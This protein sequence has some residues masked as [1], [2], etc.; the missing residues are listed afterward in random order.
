M[1]AK[2]HDQQKH[3]RRH[4]NSFDLYLLEPEGRPVDSQAF[5]AAL[6]KELCI[7]PD[8]ADPSRY[9]FVDP[10]TG[11]FFAFVL[12]PNLAALWRKLLAPPVE[13]AEGL[14]GEPDEGE[15]GGMGR[16]GSGEEGPDAADER[17]EDDEVDG[18]EEEEEASHAIEMLPL[19]L[20]VPLFCPRFFLREAL[21]FAQRLAAR[22][23]LLVEHPS[24]EGSHGPAVE[25][26]EGDLSQPLKFEDLLGP[27][28]D[29][30][31]QA[32]MAG[33]AEP[34]IWTLQKAEAWWDYSSHRA[35]LEE[36]LAI[37]APRLQAA[38]HDG[39]LKSLC[40]WEVGTPTVF[41]R[42]ELILVRQE[43]RRK[44]LFW[45]RRIVEE[46]ITAGDTI[47]DLL[48]PFG[49]LRSEPTEILIFREAERMPSQVKA[50]LE[51]LRLEPIETARRT[52]L[53][54]VLDFELEE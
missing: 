38:R 41:P 16:E 24:P 46:G 35:R 42:A 40:V 10:E 19:A 5:V 52:P 29:M 53:I 44:G 21:G 20:S 37:H 4:L 6:A 27:W 26:R 15:E 33:M 22:G 48:A 28:I 9:H 39:K 25:K 34:T 12:H 3:R 54:G 36:E 11:V 31:R 14:G 43:R 51:V 30:N 7:R 47:W 18:Q 23:G 2:E 17:E 1:S 8:P 49:E 50:A 32:C 13:D 45:S